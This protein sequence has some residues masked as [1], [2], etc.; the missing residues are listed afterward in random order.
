M[1]NKPLPSPQ[2]VPPA[3]RAQVDAFL[4]GLQRFR[5]KG[6]QPLDEAGVR[7]YDE[8][9]VKAYAGNVRERRFPGTENV[10]P[11]KKAQ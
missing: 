10:Y 7:K 5:A 2:P 1:K 8:A 3:T 9:A 11:M 4:K 6:D